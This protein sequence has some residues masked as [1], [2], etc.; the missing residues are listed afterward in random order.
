MKQQEMAT[1]GKS[2]F[3]QI[4]ATHKVYASVFSL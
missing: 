3:S 4:F 1:N 2:E